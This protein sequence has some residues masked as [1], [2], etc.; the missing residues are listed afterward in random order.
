MQTTTVQVNRTANRLYPIKLRIIFFSGIQAYMVE[1]N[2]SVQALL[3]L[4]QQMILARYIALQIVQNHV[5]GQT[6]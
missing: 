6:L 4:N 1:S 5:E 2:V 3:L